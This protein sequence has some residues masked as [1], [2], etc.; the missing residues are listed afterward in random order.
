MVTLYATLGEEAIAHGINETEVSIVITSHDLLPKFKKILNLTPRVKTLIYMEDQLKETD[1]T[2]Y[3]SDVQLLPFKSV[4]K[5]GSE[6]TVAGK[7]KIIHFKT[8]ALLDTF[9]IQLFNTKNYGV[10]RIF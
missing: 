3:K 6:F 8:N 7:Y 2:E 10:I 4:L 1:T 9:F 5:M